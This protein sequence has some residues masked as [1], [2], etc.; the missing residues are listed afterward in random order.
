MAYDG[1]IRFNTRLDNSNIE[2]D[3]RDLERKIQKAE[4]SIS[5]NEN[6]KLPLVKQAEELGNKLDEAKYKAAQLKAEM[7]SIDQAMGGGSAGDYTEAAGRKGQVAADLKTQEAEVETLQK[8]WDKLNDK[9]D[10]YDH[11]IKTAKD[12]IARSSEKAAILTKQMNGSGAAMAN[13]FARAKT[14]ALGFEKRVIAIGKRVLV[15]TL[16]ANAFRAI[17]DYMGKV[18]KTNKEHTTQLAKLK[19]ALVTAF[20][21]LYEFILPGL[22]ASLRVLTTIT[23][24][25]AN[26]MSTLFGKTLAQSAESAKKLNEEAD[27]LENVSN[28]AKKAKGNLAG[29][30]EINRM[31][32]GSS[33]TADAGDTP[34]YNFEDFNSDEY[35]K[36]IDELTVYLEGALLA[37]GAILTFSGANIPLGITLMGI[38]AAALAKD[39]SLDWTCMKTYLEGSSGLVVGALSGMALAIGAIL[40]F[41]G[42]NIPLGISLMAIGAAGLA[43]SVAANWGTMKSLLEGASGLV[44]GV[45]SGAML[46]VG[47]IL[48]FSG[49]NIPLGLGLMAVGAA[50]LAASIA[51]N[52]GTI[53]PKLQEAVD[54]IAPI[55]RTSLL[56]LGALLTFTG[57][58][59]PLGIGLM[60]A[61]AIGLAE[62]VA[63]NWNTISQTLR[64][65]VGAVVGIVSGALLALGAILTF[66]GVNLPLGIGLMAAGAV[67]LATTAAANWNSIVNALRGPIGGIVA[68]AS[69]ALL[70]LGL[71]LAL[72]GVNLPLGIALIAAGAT[73]LVT[74]TA[75]NWNSIK[76]NL[77]IAW[78]GIKSWFT[79][80]VAPKLTLT[81]WKNK[82][83][84]IATGLSQKIKDGI[85]AAIKLL[86]QFIG[87]VN[88]KLNIKW[89][90]L[91]IGGKEIIKAG[92]FQLVNIPNIPYLAQ[93]AVI[94][95][96]APFMAM[97]GD[98]KHGTN[99]EA[100]LETIQEAVALVMEDMTGGMMAGFE[101]LLE[102]NAKLRQV[103]ENIEIGDE[104]IGRAV[105]RYNSKM[106][107]MRGG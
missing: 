18:L 88:D 46:A 87:W 2:K 104:V 70:A 51:A 3:L 102:E 81:Y 79:T 42:V 10:R 32:S 99:I 19:A 80:N 106:A 29:F 71:I 94:P 24:V 20:Q 73:G 38:G 9:V 12:T 25:L 77:V 5:K 90:G 21:P 84:N 1:A 49:A 57:A 95:P 40:A 54:Q 67:G 26:L 53:K 48:A 107:V 15:L 68:L 74:V 35:K 33:T 55:F 105:A 60:A 97:L 39:A 30:D 6:E 91:K 100:P 63:V 93:G 76:D 96:N 103:V 61:G 37:I 27:A 43:A 34:T 45:L 58:N 16:I 4:E 62:Y 86:N 75:M 22:I 101:A 47:A 50:G 41:S 92:S 28:E 8:Q 66:S 52:W 17:K 82:F 7:A 36:K 23:S 59:V 98:Q 72:S 83:A 44:V 56:V 65:P 11:N 69:T 14:A 78:N 13:A 64:G 89:D 85:N 31:G